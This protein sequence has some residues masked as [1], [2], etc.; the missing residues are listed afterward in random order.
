MKKIISLFVCLTL[1]LAMLIV[2]IYST[3]E[4][5]TPS[6]YVIGSS[7]IH[8]RSSNEFVV[9][10]EYYIQFEVIHLIGNSV[11][12]TTE[13]VYYVGE[14]LNVIG[15]ANQ[16]EA[17]RATSELSINAII[18]IDT[19]CG[20][21]Y[22]DAERLGNASGHYNCHSY[23]W[24]EN[25]TDNIYWINQPENYYTDNSFYVEVDTPVIGD[26]ICYFNGEDNLH[27]GIVSYVYS[28]PAGN[29]CGSNV[30]VISKWGHYGLYKHNGYE[31]PYTDFVE[32]TADNPAATSVKYF[33][34]H[35]F[36]YSR[37]I[38]NPSVHTVRCST[39][40]YSFTD[41]HTYQSLPNGSARC[42]KCGYTSSGQ[43]IMSDPSES[44]EE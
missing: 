26:I 27:S 35:V 36:T 11:I 4:E 41:N 39:C 19:I 16:V 2:P 29:Y 40:G 44:V 28:N 20:I 5:T 3:S 31:C 18:G 22:P 43:I 21:Q 33:H 42:T 12:V 1:L 13:N 8:S 9:G 14:Y 6:A 23:A 30:E 38:L 25:S 24:H 17:L 32:H 15:T 10:A 34:S 37:N 7:G